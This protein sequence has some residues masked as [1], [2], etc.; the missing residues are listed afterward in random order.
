MLWDGA[1]WDRALGNATDG[2]LVNLGAN[3]DVT[4]T[5]GAVT[6]SATDLDI[7]N[8]VQA[9]DSVSVGDGT[10]TIVVLADGADNVSNA[11]NQLVVAS[12]LYAYDGSTWDRMLGNSTDGLLV[13]LGANNDV[14]VTSG[15][16]TASAGTNLNTSLLALE[17]GGNLA[18]A[19]TS[20]AT[21]DN[22]ISGSEAQ[23]DVITVPA[24][25]FGADADAASATGSISAKLKFIAGT[26]IPVTN[27]VAVSN[28]GLTELASAIDTEVQ[29]DIVGALP[30][31]ANAIGKL[32]AN[33]GVDIG[34]VD[35][36]SIAAGTNTIGNVVPVP[37]TSGGLTIFR[38]L[39]LDE[40]DREVKPTAGQIY[41]WTITNF[42]TTTRYIKFVNLTAANT[43]VGS[44]AVAMTIPVPGNATDDTTLVQNF[45]GQGIA[46]DTAIT[47]YAVTGLADNDTGAPGASDVAV[48]I[49]YK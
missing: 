32:A 4:V 26:G 14:T 18:A 40:T 27:T 45:G 48:T 37:A 34:D 20:L 12:M 33:S 30:A 43:T 8:L 1:T 10:N 29:C 35:V 11:N 5:S 25:P 6:V 3:N 7:R 9:T 13:N 15:T 46:F 21:L 49:F 19:A 44:S 17:A 16:V 22:C 38:H 23:V 47:V 36:L 41:G 2:A 24:D 31:G 42:A 39:D 28:A